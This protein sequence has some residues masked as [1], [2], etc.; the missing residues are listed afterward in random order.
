[1]AG[2]ELDE[3]ADQRHGPRITREERCIAWAIPTNEEL[4]IARHTN[5]LL[6]LG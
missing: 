5:A 1:M 2:L 4:I 3:D 6:S